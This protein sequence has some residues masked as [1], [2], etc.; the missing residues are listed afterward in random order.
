M[1]GRQQK[2]AVVLGAALVGTYVLGNVV[3]GQARVLGLTPAQ[4]A[5][6]TAGVAFVMRKV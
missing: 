1:T 6:A 3:K 4:L 2:A 5:L